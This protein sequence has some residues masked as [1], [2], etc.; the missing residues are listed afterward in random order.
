VKPSLLFSSAL[1]RVFAKTRFL[2]VNGE[3]FSLNNFDLQLLPFFMVGID[4]PLLF[5]SDSDLI[6]D[7]KVSLSPEFKNNGGVFLPFYDNSLSVDGFGVGGSL[8]QKVAV[9]VLQS[10]LDDVLFVITD[11]LNLENLLFSNSTGNSFVVSLDSKFDVLISW[12]AVSGYENVD[13]VVSVGTYSVRGGI[14]DVFPFSSNKPCRIGF[15]GGVEIFYFDVDSQLTIK[16]VDRVV[17]TPRVLGG[18]KNL[19]D[20]LDNRFISVFVKNGCISFGDAFGN[21]NIGVS[22]GVV[23]YGDFINNNLVDFLVEDSLE[24]FGVSVDNKI[25]VPSW[26][27]KKTVTNS[28]TNKPIVDKVSLSNVQRGDF[29]VHVDYGVGKY[30]GLRQDEGVGVE[31]LVLEF[32]DN[33]QISVSVDRFDRLSYYAASD[34]DGVELDSL[35]KPVVW[36]RKKVFAT[37]QV[38][39]F[40]FD[41]V[42][43]H[44]NR[45]V[46]TRDVYKQSGEM[47]KLLLSGFLF[48]DTPD[49]S[50]AWKDI[51]SDLSNTTPMDRLVCGDVGFGKTEVAIRA[52]FRVV[53]G[54]KQVVVLAPTTILANQLFSAFN[55]RLNSLSVSVGVVSRFVST[56]NKQLL[57][58]AYSDGC[59]DVLV[60]T[61]TL[62]FGDMSFNNTGLL[63]I[64]EEHRFGVKQKDKI[65]SLSSKI[66]VLSMSATPIPRSLHMAVSGIRDISLVQTPPKARLPIET[67]V[68]YFNE[69]IIKKAILSEVA[70]GGQIFFVHNEVKTIEVVVRRLREILPHLQIN[71]A[72]GQEPVKSLEKTMS[73]FVLGNSDVLVCTTIIETGLDVPNA[74]TII[75]NKAHRFGLAQ[76]YQIRGRVGRGSRQAFAYLMVPKNF[77]LSKT[78]FKRLKTIEQNTALGSGYD[79]S[80][81]DLEIRGAGTL[82][83]YKQSGGVGRVG[84]ELY[85]RLIKEALIKQGL[86]SQPSVVSIDRVVVKI[87]VEESIPL[88]Y[89]NHESLRVAFYRRIALIETLSYLSDLEYELVNRF[90]MFPQQ[91]QN[92]LI[93]ARLKIYGSLV[94]INLFSFKKGVFQI[95]FVDNGVVV[96][97]NQF[98]ETISL[99]FKKQNESY[100]FKKDGVNGLSVFFQ[101]INNKDSSVFLLGLMDKLLAVINNK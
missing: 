92:L 12:L 81:M 50:A 77:S 71:F 62:L 55:S 7:V 30:V 23:Q 26:F 56:K 72:H 73:E 38:E 5:I 1:S 74:N 61:H 78:A 36:N 76:L 64:D 11:L 79:I 34:V 47:E 83:G 89:I 17:V 69:G 6:Y 42:V 68:L 101:T 27:V 86:V 44:S 87:F 58:K 91:T 85:S 18:E 96:N 32:A 3:S 90:G 29:L 95:R 10:S 59:L 49:Q 88:S 70:R 66:D 9:S 84:V 100:W 94:G 43:S 33:S 65:K 60:G 22:I 39:E 75:I 20:L 2:M 21:K 48:S 46:A 25:F 93:S 16:E 67:S 45:S 15:L 13:L 24:N 19:V 63:I 8:Y 80:L 98:M 14:V 37:K 31:F 54:G 28:V 82:F 41:M 40:V 35:S 57:K 97:T 53:F 52:A 4:K 99:F 51:S